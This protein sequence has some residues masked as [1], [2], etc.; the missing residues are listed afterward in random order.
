MN[1]ALVQEQEDYFGTLKVVEHIDTDTVQNKFV[2]RFSIANQHFIRAERIKDYLSKLL[3]EGGNICGKE[4]SIMNGID[5]VFPS[6]ELLLK[7]R[8]ELQPVHSITTTF[9]NL[10]KLHAALRELK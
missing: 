7:I 4:I 9:A 10:D 1:G 3:K 6:E 2:Y 8:N 5:I